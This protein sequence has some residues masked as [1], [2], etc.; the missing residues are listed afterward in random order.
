MVSREQKKTRT[1]PT[2]DQLENLQK[3]ILNSQQNTALNERHKKMEMCFFRQLSRDLD[4]SLC[5]V[6]IH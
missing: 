2:Q 3:K 6:F 4:F 5:S 1:E